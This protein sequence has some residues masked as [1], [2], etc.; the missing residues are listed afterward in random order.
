[1]AAP[2]TTDPIRPAKL[3]K[4]RPARRVSR[5]A[6]IKV[7]EI[8]G[9]VLH[10][11][12]PYHV[13]WAKLSQLNT[14]LVPLTFGPISTGFEGD[15]GG[16]PPLHSLTSLADWGERERRYSLGPPRRTGRLVT[17]DSCIF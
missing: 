1:M 8:F 5:E 3:D 4:V 9:I 12:R 15:L 2:R 17:L 11:R 13:S 14:P 16:H 6:R 10:G 7:Q